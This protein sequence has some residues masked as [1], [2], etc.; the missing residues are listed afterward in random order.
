MRFKITRSEFDAELAL[1]P[2]LTKYETFRVEN[3]VQRLDEYFWA[4]DDA[5]A[6]AE[7]LRRYPDGMK[8]GSNAY[9][10]EA[11]LFRSSLAGSD[12]LNVSDS[13]DC[14]YGFTDLDDEMPDSADSADSADSDDLDKDDKMLDSDYRRQ[15]A[16][17]IR[18]FI[19]NY[20]PETRSSHSRTE[21]WSLDSHILE[22]LEF[23]IP[24]IIKTKNGVPTR[25]CEKARL[26]LKSETDADSG[27]CN[28]SDA[29]MKLGEEMWNEELTRLL[30]HIWTYE[31]FSGF[32]VVDAKWPID[33][34]TFLFEKKSLIPY[35]PGRYNEM[36]YQKLNELAQAEWRAIWA[37]MS[38]YGQDLWT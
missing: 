20:D 14:G 1:H 25:F 19:E 5:E 38:E 27:E 15:A 7:F 13:F 33:K 12:V 10:S 36:D 37:W 24:I 8:P 18:Y 6:E 26:Q 31:F 30:G 29:E 32:G 35:K 3:G 23:N 9:F 34:Q 16:D 11:Y 4:K 17:D 2:G 22:D 21:S 28:P